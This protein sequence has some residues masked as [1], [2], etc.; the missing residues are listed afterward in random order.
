MLGWVEI[1]FEGRSSAEIEYPDIESLPHGVNSDVGC[2]IRGEKRRMHNE[3][4]V[5]DV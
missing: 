1:D 2:F 5:Y 4:R 3:V